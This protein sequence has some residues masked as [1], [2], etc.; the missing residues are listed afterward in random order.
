MC[1]LLG[2][3]DVWECARN[4]PCTDGLVSAHSH[5]SK[6]HLRLWSA[7]FHTCVEIFWARGVFKPGVWGPGASDMPDCSEYDSFFRTSESQCERNQ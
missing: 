6:G 5:C 7:V 3:G 2:H 1:L 4:A